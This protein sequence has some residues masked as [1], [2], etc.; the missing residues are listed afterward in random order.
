VTVVGVN[1]LTMVTIQTGLS[2]IETRLAATDAGRRRLLA[3]HRSL[4]AVSFDALREH[5]HAAV[6]IWVQSVATQ[7]DFT[8]ETLIK[9]SST[10]AA[11]DVVVLGGCIPG[12]GAAVDEHVHA[13]N[14]DG[15][16]PV[17]YRP[18]PEGPQTMKK[19]PHV[20]VDEKESRERGDRS[21]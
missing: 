11:I 4:V 14:A 17:R 1:G 12:L 7:I 2:E 5:L 16:G 18:H 21:A 8:A 15:C 13:D 3:W 10:A 6:G 20:G 19:V 9:T